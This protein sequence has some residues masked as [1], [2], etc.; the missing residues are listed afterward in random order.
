MKIWTDF[1]LF[2]VFVSYY[3]KFIVFIYTFP[4]LGNKSDEEMKRWSDAMKR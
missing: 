2:L 3:G 1:Q 4:K